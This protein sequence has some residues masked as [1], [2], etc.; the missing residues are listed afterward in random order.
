MGAWPTVSHWIS[1][2]LASGQRLK[3]LGRP[4]SG[5]PAAGSGRTHTHEQGE[6]VRR[7]L[8]LHESP[9]KV[10]APPTGARMPE[11]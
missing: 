11:S 9:G 7:A 6:I 4:A 2:V 3:F 1:D 5:S 10:D 8:G